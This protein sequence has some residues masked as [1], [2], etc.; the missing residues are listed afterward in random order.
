VNEAR[1]YVRRMYGRR[2]NRILDVTIVKTP[3]TQHE[4]P[5]LPAAPRP[6]AAPVG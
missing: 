1:D 4:H 5:A 6:A 2:L 3:R